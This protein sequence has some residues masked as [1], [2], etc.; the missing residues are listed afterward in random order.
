MSG[1]WVE[2]GFYECREYLAEQCYRLDNKIDGKYMTNISSEKFK[3]YE[4][5]RK[6]LE[7]KQNQNLFRNGEKNFFLEIAK[8]IRNLFQPF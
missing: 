5:R 3:N 1:I 4:N 2:K 8:N 6:T 7:K